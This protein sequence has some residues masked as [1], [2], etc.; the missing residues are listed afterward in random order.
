MNRKIVRSLLIPLAFLCLPTF[1][2]GCTYGDDGYS[3]YDDFAPVPEPDAVYE[4]PSIPEPALVTA[5]PSVPTYAEGAH[6]EIHTYGPGEEPRF[7]DVCESPNDGIG[8]D[9]LE[10]CPAFTE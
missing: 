7:I 10:N 8:A 3:Q 5:V 6:V 1:T 2:V 9:L 4:E